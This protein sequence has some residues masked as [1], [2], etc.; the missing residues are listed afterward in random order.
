MDL[1]KG[2][3]LYLDPKLPDQYI[4]LLCKESIGTLEGIALKTK[5]K[6]FTMLAETSDTPITEN[7]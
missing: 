3:Q 7:D 5:D 2:M 1:V 6:S 4:L